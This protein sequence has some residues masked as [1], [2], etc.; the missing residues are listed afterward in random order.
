M[1]C[2][3]KHAVELAHDSIIRYVKIMASFDLLSRVIHVNVNFECFTLA[4]L[5]LW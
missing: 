1:Y 3:F 5:D 4:V 2:C